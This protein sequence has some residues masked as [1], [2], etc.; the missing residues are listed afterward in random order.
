L[1]RR[2]SRSTAGAYVTAC[3][4]NPQ[5]DEAGIAQALRQASPTASPNPAS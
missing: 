1:L 2:I 5:R 3:A 4:L